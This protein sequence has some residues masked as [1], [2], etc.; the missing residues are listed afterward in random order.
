MS[1]R[2]YRF[3]SDSLPLSDPTTISTP[4]GPLQFLVQGGN[5]GDQ[6]DS[7]AWRGEQREGNTWYAS[8]RCRWPRWRS[9][10]S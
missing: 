10:R 1:R 3:A 9:V 5:A 7:S 8:D 4:R 2:S 6:A